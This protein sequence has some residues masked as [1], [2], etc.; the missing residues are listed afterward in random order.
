[1]EGKWYGWTGSEGG[2]DVYQSWTSTGGGTVVVEIDGG[3]AMLGEEART[4]FSRSRDDLYVERFSPLGHDRAVLD[5]AASTPERWVFRADPA[6]GRL[7]GHL[8]LGKDDKMYGE[9][10]T[11]TGPHPSRLRFFIRRVK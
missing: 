7:S 8:S 4:F 3:P 2:P 6:G 1:M 11:G 10:V 5:P 9:W